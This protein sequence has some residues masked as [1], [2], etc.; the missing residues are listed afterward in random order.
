M[1]VG[2]AEEEALSWNRVRTVGEDRAKVAERPRVSLP[3]RRSDTVPTAALGSGSCANCVAMEVLRAPVMPA[4][5]LERADGKLD[6]GGTL[7]P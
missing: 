6:P 4:A 1:L 3:G 7:P 5:A 2:K